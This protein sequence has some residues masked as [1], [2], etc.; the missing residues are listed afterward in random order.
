M[1]KKFGKDF[2]FYNASINILLVF[3]GGEELFKSFIKLKY[4]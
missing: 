2:Y 3:V 1:A 4:L